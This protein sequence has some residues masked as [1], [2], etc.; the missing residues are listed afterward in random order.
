V[1]GDVA[2]ATPEA[3]LRTG[4]IR[5]LIQANIHAGEVEGKEATL[6]LLRSLASGQ[7]SEWSKSLVILVLPLFNADGKAPTLQCDLPA[8]QVQ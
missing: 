8:H 6:M 1:W 3:V 7:H 4:K 2:D 5:V